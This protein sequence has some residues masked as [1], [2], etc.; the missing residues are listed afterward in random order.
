[1]LTRDETTFIQYTLASLEAPR[2]V[3][4]SGTLAEVL[5][6]PINHKEVDRLLDSPDYKAGW[7]ACQQ[8]FADYLET[9][10]QANGPNGTSYRKAVKQVAAQFRRDQ[11]RE[12][13]KRATAL[14]IATKKVE[15]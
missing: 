14:E 10:L 5:A 1:M 15:T 12:L 8:Q 13:A 7:T 11:L 3:A 4:K 2:V 6:K 9:L